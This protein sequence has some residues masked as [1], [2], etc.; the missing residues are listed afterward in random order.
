MRNQGLFQTLEICVVQMTKKN[1]YT[2]SIIYIGIARF[3]KIFQGFEGNLQRFLEKM[4]L[5]WL[6]CLKRKHKIFV[7]KKYLTL[8]PRWNVFWFF[9]YPVKHVFA[10][11]CRVEDNDS[12]ILKEVERQNFSHK[13]YL[14]GTLLQIT[15]HLQS[16]YR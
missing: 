11:M 16:D 1:W 14:K 12:T 15:G 10:I 6:L 2:L 8:A 13:I 3:C 4:I 9:W 5:K 7:E